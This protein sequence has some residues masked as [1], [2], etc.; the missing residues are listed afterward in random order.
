MIFEINVFDFLAWPNKCILAF[1]FFAS[2]IRNSLQTLSEFRTTIPFLFN[3]RNILLFLL[4]H[5][6]L[7]TQMAT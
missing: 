5:V 1:I 4:V 7:L 3:P 2:F 6:Q